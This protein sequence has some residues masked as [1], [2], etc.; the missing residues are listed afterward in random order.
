MKAALKMRWNLAAVSRLLM[1]SILLT[2]F[3]A[4]A[5]KV[6]SLVYKPSIAK[7]LQQSQ[8]LAFIGTDKQVLEINL[9]GI[10]STQI[11]EKSG[12]LATGFIYPLP[13]PITLS[14][15]RWEI[16]NGLSVAR[17][18]IISDNAKRLRIHLAGMDTNVETSFRIRGNQDQ[19]VLGPVANKAADNGEIWLPIT[20]GNSADLEIAVADT[21]Q[22]A[23]LK[24]NLDQVNLILVDSALAKK[25]LVVQ[26]KKGDALEVEF[27]LACWSGSADYGGLKQAAAATALVDFIENGR[28]YICSGTLLNDKG[29][30]HTPWFA[31]ANHCI[32]DQTTASTAEFSWLYQAESCNSTITDSRYAQ[33]VGGA[34]LLW[35]NFKYDAAFLKLNNPPA[36]DTVFAGWDVDI[37]YFDEV[38]GVHHPEGD[39]TMVSKGSVSALLQPVSDNSGG[40]YT[41]DNIKFS[42]GGTESGS[43]G[44]GLFSIDTT[45]V[46]W[47][48]TLFGGSYTDYQDADYSP[49]RKYYD[50]IKPWLSSCALPWGGSITDG[51]QVIAYQADASQG[52]GG[53]SEVRVCADGVLSG[54]YMN[55]G[56]KVPTVDAVCNFNG[57]RYENGQSYIF[58]QQ[59]SSSNCETIAEERMCNNGV[60]S[61]SYNKSYCSSH[62]NDMVLWT[63]NGD[64]GIVYVPGK[65]MKIS[66]DLANTYSYGSRAKKVN[67]AISKDSGAHWI[68]LKTGVKNTGSWKWKVNKSK[69]SHKGRIR[70]CV[71]KTKKKPAICDSSDYDF[72]INK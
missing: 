4:K 42:K 50:N 22:V 64:E 16:V 68:S 49:F 35:S 63:P 27:D 54:S 53:T 67:I 51:Q 58:Y 11:P 14:Q 12:V 39:H 20:Q 52:C 48:G 15:L 3:P 6:E 56:C 31:T 44:S 21:A 55:Q 41:L 9:T 18:R 28:S 59:Y 34:E 30:T 1:L 19:Q 5:D 29:G 69:V 13:T 45:H 26:K 10:Q 70:V 36:A 62:D 7:S 8:A 57:N 23:D 37:N 24:L 40:K 32:G 66:W 71:P 46:Y 72:V 60:L 47:K 61:G 65:S 17:I 33:T 43:S 38:Y 25:S 2:A